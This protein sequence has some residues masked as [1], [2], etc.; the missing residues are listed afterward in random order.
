MA[1]TLYYSSIL[2]GST[3]HYRD[4]A[5]SVI[6][7]GGCPL[8]CPWCYVPALMDRRNSVPADA[9][10]FVEHFRLHTDCNA[11]CITG[12]EP[13]D[14]GDAMLELC[15]ALH[16]EGILVKAETSGFCPDALEK[17]LPFIDYIALDLKTALDLDAYFKATGARG[18][19]LTII[20][21]VIRSIEIIKRDRRVYKEFRTT[22]VPSL[23]DK[24]EIIAAI[25]KIA[26]G[27]D[28]Y[29]LQQ[30]RADLELN[31]PLYQALPSTSKQVLMDLAF[32]AK[33]HCENVYIRTV[34]DGEIKL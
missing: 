20:T 24:P 23:S 17:A 22:V 1:S 33:K 19:P 12:G 14:Q 26:S 34:D 4:R 28:S 18:S 9:K 15:E 2:D 13:F 11:A 16:H 3:T 27:A 32:E 5:C 8:R 30:F 21:N 6:F 31:D 10:F 7:L 29:V 25:A